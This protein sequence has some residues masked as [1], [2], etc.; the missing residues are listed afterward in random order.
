MSRYPPFGLR[1]ERR[2]LK[3]FSRTSSSRPSGATG[4]GRTYTTNL[5]LNTK[6]LDFVQFGWAGDQRSTDGTRLA[7]ERLG[8]YADYALLR[9]TPPPEARRQPQKPTYIF[10]GPR[11][12]YRMPKAE[13]P[14]QETV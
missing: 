6:G 12:G 5:N 1:A 4:P 2:A 9:E 11:V 13:T 3:L 7:R 8:R 10:N 14:E